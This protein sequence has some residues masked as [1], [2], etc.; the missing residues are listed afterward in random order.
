MIGYYD[1]DT[2]K[3]GES[4]GVIS[5]VNAA[6]AKDVTEVRITTVKQAKSVVA[7][8]KDQITHG[9]AGSEGS[10][11]KVRGTFVRLPDSHNEGVITDGK[12]KVPARMGFEVKQGDLPLRGLCIAMGEMVDGALMVSRMTLAPIGPIPSPNQAIQTPDS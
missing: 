6:D 10:F 9:L 7:A 11:R 8:L 4:E 1:P 2:L 5:F 3:V 12:A